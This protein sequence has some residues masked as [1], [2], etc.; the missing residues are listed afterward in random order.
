[1]WKRIGFAVALMIA[2]GP[3]TTGAS[4]A[5][6]KAAN[7]RGVALLRQKDYKGAIAQF[8]KAIGEDKALVLAHYNLACAA[9]LAQD[10]DTAMAELIWVGNRAAWD[11]QA[12]SAAIKAAK[13][14]DL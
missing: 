5:G 7:T 1:M 3:S 11:D 8:R 9:S 13:D 10:M 4:P 12:K 14:P 6:A 2:C